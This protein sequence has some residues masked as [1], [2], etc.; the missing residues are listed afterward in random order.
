MDDL[1]DNACW[2]SLAGRHAHLG[3]RRGR[4]ARYDPD[5][6]VFAAVEGPVDEAGWRD[7]ASLV[8]PGGVAVLFRDSVPDPPAGWSVDARGGGLQMVLDGDLAPDESSRAIEIRALTEHDAE[9]MV[10]LVAIAQPGP[11]RPA[12][13]RMGGYHGVVDDGRLVAM[14]GERL[15]FDGYTEISA[16]CTHPDERGRG[17]ASAVTRSVASSIVGRG[18]RPFLHVAHGNAAAVGVYE[19]LG[20]VGRRDIEFVRV[21][22]PG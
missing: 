12:T 4:A 1:L 18:E 14:A 10:G 15:T 5:V 13:H 17:L 9:Q 20:F 19:R 16:V 6:S 21:V 11:F 3:E 2:S 22:A 7:L 8:G